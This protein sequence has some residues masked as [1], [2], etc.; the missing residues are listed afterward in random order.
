M[1]CTGISFMPKGSFSCGTVSAAVHQPH[2]S[3]AELRQ[4][5]ESLVTHTATHTLELG[6][7]GRAKRSKKQARSSVP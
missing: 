2:G 7:R 5:A 1:G 3:G 6:G 4:E